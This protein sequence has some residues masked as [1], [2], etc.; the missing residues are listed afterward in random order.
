M[1]KKNEKQNLV[2]KIILWLKKNSLSIFFI[3]NTIIFFSSKREDLY[4]ACQLL[5]LCELMAFLEALYII[6]NIIKKFIEH[7]LQVAY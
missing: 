5:I 3:L 4:A 1:K 2:C 6:A 7:L